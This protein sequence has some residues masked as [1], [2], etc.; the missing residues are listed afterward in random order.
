V[1]VFISID[2]EGISGL[3]CG[4]Q[5]EPGDPA[6]VRDIDLMRADLDAALAGCV[7]AGADE[8]VVCDAHD[9][10]ANLSFRDL[11]AGVTLVSGSPAPLSMM[12]G[13]DASFDAA[14]FVGYH[15]RAGTAAAV[16][17]HTYTGFVFRVR[18]DEHL[19][20]G[21]LGINAGVAGSFGVPVV[22][23]SGDDKVALEAA[24]TIPRIETAVVK[25]GV[26]RTA[27]R[28][29][30]P[31]EAHRRIRE[32][33]ERALRADHKPDPLRFDG[34]PM[35][36]VFTKTEYCD[37]ASLCPAVTRVNARA[38]D[39]EATDYLAVYQ[40]FLTALDLAEGAAPA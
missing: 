31:D 38:I 2:L 26:A 4:E 37:R 10:G 27:A 34:M 12:A 23:L 11:P 36:V 32:G 21:E 13:I 35:R 8:V 3:Y 40:A 14:L 20:V 39:I 18:L 5:T 29:L 22:F 25:V 19:E 15:A 17:D 16:I 6:Y 28:L 1:R 9:R 30:A 33:V 7:A 24:E